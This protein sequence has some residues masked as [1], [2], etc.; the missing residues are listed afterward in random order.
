MSH[1]GYEY[2]PSGDRHP[3]VL[4]IGT[5]VKSWIIERLGGPIPYWRAMLESARI[6]FPPGCESREFRIFRT[7]FEADGNIGLDALPDYEPLASEYNEWRRS[8]RLVKDVAHESEIL[9]ADASKA[10]VWIPWY[11][12]RGM[13][14]VVTAPLFL[15][16][17]FCIAVSV[18]GATVQGLALLRA[19]YAVFGI[20]G[21]FIAVSFGWILVILPPVLYYSLIKNVPGV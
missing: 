14:T 15:F 11:F 12:K 5:K 8:V 10:S 2:P 18:L 19:S 7:M 17:V 16:L 20:V 4:A 9:L 1:P 21:V 6:W 13:L 3:S